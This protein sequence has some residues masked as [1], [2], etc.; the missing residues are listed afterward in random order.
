MCI[1][2]IKGDRNVMKKYFQNILIKI[3]KKNWIAM[4]AC[5]V[6]LTTGS[7]I[8]SGCSATKENSQLQQKTD[9]NE[10]GLNASD[11][12]SKV[13]SQQFSKQI[14]KLVYIEKFDGK[15]LVFDE[16]EWVEVPGKRA[17]ELGITEDD[18]PSG[19]KVY[20]E[21]VMT[22]ELPVTRNCICDLLN[23]TS[24]YDRMQVTLKK[25]MKILADRKGTKIPYYLTIE[26]NK[27]ICITEHYVP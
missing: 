21:K 9:S 13:S 15:E 26:D 10:T 19:F 23:W 11:E 27:I 1:Y 22:E 14:E 18:A 24:N 12:E 7:G 2:Y 6:I 25:F 5:A 3:E 20:N 16:V 8:L 4:L 17:K